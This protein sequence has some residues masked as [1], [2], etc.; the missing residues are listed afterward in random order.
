MEP[1][2]KHYTK[3]GTY[4]IA[5][6]NENLNSKRMKEIKNKAKEKERKNKRN[7]SEISRYTE[8][9]KCVGVGV[10]GGVGVGV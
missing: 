2:R 1:T 3:N 7:K 4:N 10:F 8:N 5:K 9:D 6:R